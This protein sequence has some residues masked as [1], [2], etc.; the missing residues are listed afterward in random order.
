MD[1]AGTASC[2]DLVM[3]ACASAHSSDSLQGL[4]MDPSVVQAMLACLRDVHCPLC[5]LGAVLMAY[6]RLTFDVCDAD[7]AKAVVATVRGFPASHAL[8]DAN[9]PPLHSLAHLPTLAESMTRTDAAENVACWQDFAATCPSPVD[10][11]GAGDDDDGDEAVVRLSAQV[12]TDDAAQ[13]DADV[14]VARALEMV[15]PTD[16]PF[17]GAVLKLMVMMATDHAAPGACGTTV[18]EP[19]VWPLSAPTAWRAARAWLFAQGIVSVAECRALDHNPD[20]L[21][22]TVIV[23]RVQRAFGMHPGEAWDVAGF[24]KAV[25]N[26]AE[27]TR[28]AEYRMPLNLAPFHTANGAMR[29]RTTQ[30]APAERVA[31]SCDDVVRDMRAVAYWDSLGAGVGSTAFRPD[32]AHVRA[33]AL[34]AALRTLTRMVQSSTSAKKEVVGDSTVRDIVLAD[35]LRRLAMCGHAVVEPMAHWA[36]MFLVSSSPYVR[37]S[38]GSDTELCEYVVSRVDVQAAG[39]S[40]TAPA[41]P[42]QSVQRQSGAALAAWLL[43]FVAAQPDT[44]AAVCSEL[45]LG[46]FSSVLLRRDWSFLPLV[47]ASLRVLATVVRTH[48]DARTLLLS[49]P[50]VPV[51]AAALDAM[52]QW[53]RSVQRLGAVLLISFVAR[54]NAAAKAT[55]AAHQDGRVFR[56]LARV[57]DNADVDYRLVNQADAL[58]LVEACASAVVTIVSNSP[59]AQVAVAAQPSIIRVAARTLVLPGAR[60]TAAVMCA[61]VLRAVAAQHPRGQL[62]A[63]AAGGLAACLDVCAS[64]F[65]DARSREQA[66]AAVCSILTDNPV[67]CGMAVDQ[68]DE[69]IPVLSQLVTSDGATSRARMHACTTL[70][71][72]LLH[73]SSLRARLAADEHLVTALHVLCGADEGLTRA[74]AARFL[75]LVVPEMRDPGAMDAAMRRAL[76]ARMPRFPAVHAAAHGRTCGVCLDAAADSSR[77]WMVLFCGHAFHVHCVEEWLLRGRDTCGVCSRPVLRLVHRALS[78]RAADVQ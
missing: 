19:S 21:L 51:L 64:R 60:G 20:A 56:A 33:A 35:R 28:V 59:D 61:G 52:R 25:W 9:A 72:M 36:L 22:R 62:L 44:R 40:A 39:A 26:G 16:R 12:D 14:A 37:A 6:H 67:T 43:H 53:H 38:V 49:Q 10:C 34:T 8:P 75:R 55:L 32:G 68:A 30:P 27:H 65:H 71:C 66:V 23:P 1:N 11:A 63:V 13:A 4:F 18:S 15:W 48:A 46:A 54:G 2:H 78:E 77:P 3:T 57:M 69:F 41:A 31:V 24:M 5:N 73:A 17:G 29:T 76:F 47:S 50:G 7:V 42:S 70:E 74:R 58:D 45:A